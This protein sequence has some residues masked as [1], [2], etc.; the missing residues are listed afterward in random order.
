MNKQHALKNRFLILI[1]LICTLSCMKSASPSTKAAVPSL[2]P[3]ELAVSGV[4]NYA[5]TC[6]DGGGVRY[7]ADNGRV[8]VFDD[9]S[10]IRPDNYDDSMTNK[11]KEYLNVHTWLVYKN[12]GL[13]RCEFGMI[14]NQCITDSVV[15]IVSFTKY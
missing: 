9:S 13:S 10:T 6:L 12:T 14:A 1:L 3:G 5:C 11:Y 4:L 7:T 8:L 2:K 15:E